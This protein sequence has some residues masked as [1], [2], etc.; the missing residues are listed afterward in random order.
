VGKISL[1]S[2]ILQFVDLGGQSGIRSIWPRYYAD[3]HA[4]LYVLDASDAERL[5]EGWEVFGAPRPPPFRGPPAHAQ[6]SPDAVLSAPQI[7]SVPLLLL[8]NKQ[9][10]PGALS[11]PE[12]RAAYEAWFQAKREAAS[13][14]APGEAHEGELRRERVASL[15]VMGVSALEGSVV[16]T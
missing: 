7:L 12:I 5:G 1:P 8:A 13:H 11:T 16:S 10:A 6:A 14:R 2:T 3:C 9:D 4:V 15:D